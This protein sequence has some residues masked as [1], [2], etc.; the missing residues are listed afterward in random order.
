M[1]AAYELQKAIYATLKADA[2][3]IALVG[4]RVFDRVPNNYDTFPYVKIGEDVLSQWDTDDANGFD[5]SITI[6]CYSRYSGKKE[7]KQIQGAIYA[8]LHNAAIT[9]TGYNVAMLQ[10][11][12]QN[13]LDEADGKTVHGVQTF[14]VLIDEN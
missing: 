14:R 6:H 3:V 10:Q 7:A 5:G 9:V 12:D 2:G 11:L 4:S 13:A 8:A 1:S